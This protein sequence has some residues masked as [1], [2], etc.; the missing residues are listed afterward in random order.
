[1]P[2][3]TPWFSEVIGLGIKNLWLCHDSALNPRGPWLYDF[4]LGI[5]V[6]EYGPEVA[7]QP[8]AGLERLSLI[9]EAAMWQWGNASSSPLPGYG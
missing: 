8:G 3:A 5:S 6:H 9:Q 1:M 2:R 7:G 4:F